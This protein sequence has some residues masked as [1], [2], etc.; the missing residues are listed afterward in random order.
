MVKLSTWFTFTAR[1]VKHSV[2]N[3]VAR[4]ILDV[5]FD[6]GFANRRYKYLPVIAFLS[7][8]FGKYCFNFPESCVILMPNS[9]TARKHSKFRAATRFPDLHGMTSISHWHKKMETV[10]MWGVFYFFLC[11]LCDLCGESFM[12][13]CAR[14]G[15]GVTYNLYNEQ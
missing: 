2:V 5:F 1:R 9:L 6:I 8:S 15:M 7:D 10:N 12:F 14:Q 4:L 13:Y 3:L 11:V